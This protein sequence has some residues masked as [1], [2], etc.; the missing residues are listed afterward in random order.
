MLVREAIE[1]HLPPDQFKVLKV[2]EAS[3]RRLIREFVGTMKGAQ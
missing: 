2:A 1:Q 3:E